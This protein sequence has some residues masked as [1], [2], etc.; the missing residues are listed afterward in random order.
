MLIEPTKALSSLTMT[1]SSY[2]HLCLQ[3]MPL[4]VFRVN[5]CERLY[6]ETPDSWSFIHHFPVNKQRSSQCS[7]LQNLKQ[8]EDFGHLAVVSRISTIEENLFQCSEM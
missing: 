2:F 3:N 7:D 8:S 4:I 1:H 5:R 6:K